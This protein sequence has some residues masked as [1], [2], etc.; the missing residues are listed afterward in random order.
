MLRFMLRKLVL[1]S[2]IVSATTLAADKKPEERLD[3]AFFNGK[4]FTG[5]GIS[6]NNK[7][8]SEGKELW[9]VL[10]D[11]TLRAE[12]DPDNNPKTRQQSGLYTL[13]QDYGNFELSFDYRYTGQEQGKNSGV[14]VLGGEK[15]VDSGGAFPASI[16]V[17]LRLKWEGDLLL[18]QLS[19]KPEQGYQLSADANKANARIAA[20][21]EGLNIDPVSDW[22]PM[23]IRVEP[24]D[25]D[26][27]TVSVWLNGQLVN[28]GIHAG[29]DQG[30]II[31]QSEGADIEWRNIKLIRFD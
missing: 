12:G 31:F 8:A 25:N 4:D 17:Q 20:R 23:K 1:A 21:R 7:G 11:G 16:E 3:S 14:W 18:K 6:T 22:T 13:S 24:T 29:R 10:A 9:S 30:R 5:W 28:K 2:V 19:L 27:T 26:G 15:F